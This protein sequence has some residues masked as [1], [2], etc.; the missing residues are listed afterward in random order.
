MKYAEKMLY[1]QSSADYQSRQHNN[2][3]LLHSTGNKPAGYEIDSSIN[4]V[5]Y[6][7]IEALTRY[8]DFYA[9]EDLNHNENDKHYTLSPFTYLSKR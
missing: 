2:A 8:R 3:F 4:Y 6:Y 7:Y 5:D 1:L 9:N